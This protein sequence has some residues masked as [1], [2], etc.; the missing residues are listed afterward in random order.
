M[1]NAYRLSGDFLQLNLEMSD[2]ENI[3]FA[4]VMMLESICED[5]SHVNCNN[6]ALN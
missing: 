4:A 5:L 3:D 6:T 1:E 2:I